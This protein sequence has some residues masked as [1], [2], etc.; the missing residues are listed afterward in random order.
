M[1]DDYLWDRSGPPDADI[2][3]L[4]RLLGTLRGTPAVPE[5]P[6]RPAA[7][8]A[9]WSSRTFL[10]A[11]AALVL[12]CAGAVWQMHATPGGPSWS[13]VRVDGSPLVGGTPLSGVGRLAVNDPDTF[14][15]KRLDEF[16]RTAL[17][18]RGGG[19]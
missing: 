2:E 9:A 5:W 8:R 3:R 12:A 7:A 10:A 18:L 15:R 6:A 11:A 17:S 4:E 1:S 13:V 19:S 16:A 14:P